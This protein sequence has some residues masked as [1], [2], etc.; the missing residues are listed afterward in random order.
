MTLGKERDQ[1]VR[2]DIDPEVVRRDIEHLKAFLNWIR[3]NC[4]VLPCTAALQINRFLK[5]K[6]TPCK[7]AQQALSVT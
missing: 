4:D 1:Y 3:E 7:R 5:R 6:D 2:T